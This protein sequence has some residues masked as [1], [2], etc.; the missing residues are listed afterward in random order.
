MSGL[1]MEYNMVN[2][3]GSFTQVN[4]EEQAVMKVAEL[5][6]GVAAQRGDESND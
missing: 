5:P 1:S 3:D 2:P 4:P 6:F